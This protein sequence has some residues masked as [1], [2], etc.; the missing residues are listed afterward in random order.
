MTTYIETFEKNGH[1][2]QVRHDRLERHLDLLLEGHRFL[3]LGGLLLFVLFLLFLALSYYIPNLLLASLDLGFDLLCFG[4]FLCRA[5]KLDL[6]LNFRV[7]LRNHQLALLFDRGFHLQHFHSLFFFGLR[8]GL[9]LLNCFLG[10]LG[11]FGRFLGDARNIIYN[12][13]F[14]VAHYTRII[15]CGRLGAR[16]FFEMYGASLFALIHHQLG[17]LAE[18]LEPNP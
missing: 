4:L 1:G 8:C 12:L 14:I 10:L 13:D 17:D 11:D 7:I 18:L 2:S 15:R 5:Q 3:F 6:F 9:L 16:D